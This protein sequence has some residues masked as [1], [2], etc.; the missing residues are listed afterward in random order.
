MKNSTTSIIALYIGIQLVSCS[1]TPNTETTDQ[2]APAVIP[3]AAADTTDTTNTAQITGE[4][5]FKIV[6][7]EFSPMTTISVLSNG[8]EYLVDEIVGGATL[9]D[10]AEFETM[11]IPSTALSACGAWWAGGGDYFYLTQSNN[12]LVVF[13]GWLDEMEEQDNGYHWEERV[14]LP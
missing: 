5:S 1:T 12:Q 2:A 4:F 9:I 3:T 6:E 10:K 14:R 8:K 11:G 13:A 7:G